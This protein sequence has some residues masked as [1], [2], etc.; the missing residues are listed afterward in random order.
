MA[1]D[2][3]VWFGVSG[4]FYGRRGCLEVYFGWMGLVGYIFSSWHG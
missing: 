1:K 2:Y 4:Y 3:F